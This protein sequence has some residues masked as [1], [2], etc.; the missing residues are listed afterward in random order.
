MIPSRPL[1][2]DVP[3]DYLINHT[4]EK[5]NEKLDQLLSSRSTWIEDLLAQ[6]LTGDDI[7]RSYLSSKA[8]RLKF[9]SRS[10]VV[11]ALNRDLSCQR[12]LLM[13]TNL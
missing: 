11:S 10:L 13:Q 4:Q 9:I 8:D 3:L 12:K 1:R 7:K 2:L 5:A 6:S